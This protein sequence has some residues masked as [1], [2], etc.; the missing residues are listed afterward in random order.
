[1]RQYA[2]CLGL[3]DAGQARHRRARQVGSRRALGGATWRWAGWIQ[4]LFRGDTTQCPCLLRTTTPQ[5][6]GLWL[7][8]TL[9]LWGMRRVRQGGLSSPAVCACA[10]E[11]AHRPHGRVG[12]PGC[13]T[14]RSEAGVC[15]RAAQG[16]PTLPSPDCAWRL[17][18]TARVE[19][20]ALPAVAPGLERARAGGGGRAGL[21]QPAARA[22]H[23]RGRRGRRGRAR[24]R[25]RRGR[26][27]P[28]HP[29]RRRVCQR[30]GRCRARRMGVWLA[31]APRAALH[32]R[33]HATPP[34]PGP[35]G[36]GW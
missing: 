8:V 6:T 29:R 5:A 30:A 18:H 14:R 15:A 11:A 2:V 27:L 28:R 3:L 35:A 25:R 34:Q 16:Q 36:T 21:P 19:L 4:G 31:A 23:R 1:M 13:R 12:A 9:A 10:G 20:P 17:A 33:G 22:H 24:G 32:P 26:A 7:A